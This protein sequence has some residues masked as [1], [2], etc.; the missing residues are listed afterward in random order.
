MY[1]SKTR[2]FSFLLLVVIFTVMLTIVNKAQDKIP[3]IPIN[4]KP[5][6][7]WTVAASTGTVQERANDSYGTM[8][9]TIVNGGSKLVVRYNVTNVSCNQGKMPWN[10]P[11]HTLELAHTTSSAGMV[12]AT[13]YELDPC[14]NKVTLLCSV[15]GKSGPTRC[16][17][18]NFKPVMDFSSTNGKIYF[19]E[20]IMDSRVSVHSLRIY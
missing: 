11:W 19:V 12:V 2:V 10:P 5:R 18:C 20:V 3:D 17:T 16:D 9:G 1:Y 4:G 13:L 15:K 14:S 7:A 6:C 8:Q